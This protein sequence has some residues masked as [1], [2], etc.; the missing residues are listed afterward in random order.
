MFYG[1]GYVAKPVTKAISKPLTFISNIFKK[2]RYAQWKGRGWERFVGNY[3]DTGRT[4]ARG[5]N[6]Y[7]YYVQWIVK[8]KLFTAKNTRWAI[9][10]ILKHVANWNKD[11]QRNIRDHLATIKY[12]PEPK[13]VPPVEVHKPSASY[14]EEAITKVVSKPRDI[15]S[16]TPEQ[17]KKQSLTKIPAIP[18]IPL[19]IL[20]GAGALFLIFNLTK[21]KGGAV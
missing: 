14:K 10:W 20:I 16:A 12:L 18:K 5:Y 1:Y 9:D 6:Y 11:M 7:P 15:R 13:P 4:H 8:G 19:Y 3:H 21:T 2:P 17:I